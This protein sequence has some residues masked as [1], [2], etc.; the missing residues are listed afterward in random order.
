MGHFTTKMSKVVFKA[1]PGVFGDKGFN[2]TPGLLF[3]FDISVNPEQRERDH[4]F[5]YLVNGSHIKR[6][7]CH[8]QNERG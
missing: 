4:K 5:G 7:Q 2:K 3:V 6:F 8:S 1:T